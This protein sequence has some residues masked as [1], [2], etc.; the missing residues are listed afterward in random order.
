MVGFM[1]WGNDTWTGSSPPALHVRHSVDLL[2]TTERFGDL[3]AI[4]ETVVPRLK[5]NLLPLTE[6]NGV[7]QEQR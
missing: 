6:H 5:K 7:G 1:S 2:W 3:F 4:L